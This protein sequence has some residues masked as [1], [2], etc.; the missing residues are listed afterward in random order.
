MSNENTVGNKQEVHVCLTIWLV[1]PGSCFA[2][3]V[4]KL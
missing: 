2:D 3:D 1:Q 4:A